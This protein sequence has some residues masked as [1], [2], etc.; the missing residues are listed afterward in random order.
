MSGSLFI[1]KSESMA[2]VQDYLSSEPFQLAKIQDYQVEEE[3]AFLYLKDLILVQDGEVVD[4]L[5][6]YLHM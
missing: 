2:K 4:T 6:T 3:D 5:F 1:M